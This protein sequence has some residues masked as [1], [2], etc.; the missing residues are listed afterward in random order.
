MRTTYKIHIL[1]WIMFMILFK[2]LLLSEAFGVNEHFPIY[3][4][5]KPNVEFWK[6]VYK[7]YSTDQGI[8]HDSKD[9]K[10]IYGVIKLEKPAKP[11]AS[12]INRK[13]IKKAKNKFKAILTQLIKNPK[14]PSPEARRVARLFGLN[15]TRQSFRNAKGNMRCQVGQRDRFRKGL[16]RSGA[17][18]EEIKRIFKSRGL[19]SDLAYLPHVESSFNPKAYSKF[20]ASGI[21]QFTRSTGKRYMTVGYTMDERRDPIRSSY[22][23]SLFLKDNYKKLGSW[24]LAITAYNHG[25]AGM[26]RAK[27]QKGNYEA[28][29]KYHKS[30]L[31]GFA[32]RNFYSEFLAALEVAKNHERYFGKLK[33]V[34]PPR[35]REVKMEGYASMKDLARV[36]NVGIDTIRSLNPSLRDPVFKGQ[37][38]VPKGYK[39]KLPSQNDQ[40]PLNMANRSLT[41]LYKS[42]QKRSRFYTVQKGDTA[43][44]ISKMHGVKLFD[45]IM[46]NGLGSKATIFPRQN[47]RIPAPDEDLVRPA[48][49]ITLNRSVS[50]G[51]RKISKSSM[52][53]NN[54]K[55]GRQSPKGVKLIRSSV[56]PSVVTS[57][58]LVEQFIQKSG[59]RFGIIR[60]ESAETL[61]HYAEWLGIATR[62]I[63]Q[64][65][66]FT[67]GRSIRAHQRVKIPLDR[68]SKQ[69]FEEKRFEYHKE[70]EEDFFN[71]YKVE[72]IRIYPVAN[73]DNLW[74]LCLE[75]FELPFWLIMKYNPGLDFDTLRPSQELLV[76]VVVS[77]G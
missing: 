54:D 6:N 24:P 66:G 53:V 67:Y 35:Y 41:S 34:S 70:I 48:S 38:Y 23:A 75:T 65:N 19:S 77:I 31:F 73:G 60:V 25:T 21:W 51:G 33:L 57:N 13:R 22:A 50:H 32:S 69:E 46:A 59:K 45:L 3:P 68:I 44:K 16:I 72:N 14:V 8:I 5:I 20:G 56:N 42:N 29:F 7:E 26:L 62:K 52:R 47:L 28:I 18:L 27:R 49:H 1:G 4:S 15:P 71:S 10:I 12:R 40:P 55:T 30:R 58:L 64:L 36:F 17:Y 63:R 37:K 61:G 76:P 39:L 9:L 43:G 2:T 11:G 74:T